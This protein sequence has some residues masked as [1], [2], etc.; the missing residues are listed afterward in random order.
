MD[1]EFDKGINQTSGHIYKH[2]HIYVAAE[3]IA[4]RDMEC[5]CDYNPDK[6]PFED[7]TPNPA[8]PKDPWKRPFK[9]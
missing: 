4:V 3:M 7:Y 1:N 9:K 2:M 6:C 5:Y 8:N